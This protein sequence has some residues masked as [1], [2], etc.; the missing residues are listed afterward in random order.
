MHKSIK[1]RISQ[2]DADSIALSEDRYIG[3][4]ARKMAKEEINTVRLCT[5]TEG[6]DE[7]G[8]KVSCPWTNVLLWSPL[9]SSEGPLVST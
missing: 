7:A 4:K 6:V 9:M 5:K 2:T 1:V 3:A 8:S